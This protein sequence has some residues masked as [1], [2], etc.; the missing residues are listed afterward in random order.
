MSSTP[1]RD[2]SPG[3]PAA[4][5]STLGDDLFNEAYEKALLRKQ[6][7]KDYLS[8]HQVLERFNLALEA[9]FDCSELPEDPVPY[10]MEKMKNNRP[11][12]KKPSNR[13]NS[14]TFKNG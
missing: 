4:E 6:L 1:N 2:I 11:S 14:A 8:R 7:F 10:L 9:L 3:R 13:P 12:A 5:A